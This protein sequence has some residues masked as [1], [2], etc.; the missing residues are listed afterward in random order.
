MLDKLKQRLFTNKDVKKEYEKIK[1]EFD[2]FV[3]KYKQ[4]YNL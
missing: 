2:K 3:E 1:P 4:K